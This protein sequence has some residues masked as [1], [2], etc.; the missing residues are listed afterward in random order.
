MWLDV[1]GK[2]QVC[3]H[4]CD[5]SVESVTVRVICWEDSFVFV[6]SGLLCLEEEEKKQYKSPGLWSLLTSVKKVY[7]RSKTEKY[8]FGSKLLLFPAIWSPLLSPASFCWQTAEVTKPE[9][10]S[11]ER[12]PRMLL[13]SPIFSFANDRPCWVWHGTPQTWHF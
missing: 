9:E 10:V 6:G 11:S 8:V 5:L 13:S 12:C 4:C 3:R 1:T 7:F 2:F